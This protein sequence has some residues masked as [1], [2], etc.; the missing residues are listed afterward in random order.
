MKSWL[1]LGFIYL[2]LKSDQKLC[3]SKLSYGILE[4]YFLFS[5]GEKD[6]G[7]SNEIQSLACTLLHLKHTSNFWLRFDFPVGTCFGWVS[8]ACKFHFYLLLKKRKKVNDYCIFES[9]KSM[10]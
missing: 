10:A 2:L 5:A 4:F 7:L 6:A 3:K 1:Q 9:V 8:W